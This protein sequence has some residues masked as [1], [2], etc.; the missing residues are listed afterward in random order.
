MT[1]WLQCQVVRGGM[2][3]IERVVEVRTVWG[4][5]SAFFVRADE[6]EGDR[7]RVLAERSPSTGNWEVILPTDHPY[8]AVSVP[9]EDLE[10]R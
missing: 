8:M 10:F 7:V 3:S 1:A 5:T 4:T 9:E 6:V 2:F